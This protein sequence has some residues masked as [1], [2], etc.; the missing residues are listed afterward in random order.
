MKRKL[1]GMSVDV[2]D[3]LL[4]GGDFF[5]FFI[6][7]FALEF[8]FQRHYQLNRIQGIRTQIIDVLK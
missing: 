5:G 7:N 8:F 2:I 1:L 3:S 4:H 6:R